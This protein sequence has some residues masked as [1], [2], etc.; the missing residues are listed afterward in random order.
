[1]RK[2]I[3]LFTVITKV[4]VFNSINSTP[5]VAI[6]YDPLSP[7]NKPNPFEELL[8]DAGYNVTS[9]NS[10]DATD[11]SFKSVPKTARLI[12]MRL[13][14]S[15]NQGNVWVFSGE[16]YSKEKTLHRYTRG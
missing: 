11:N 14:S 12:I 3:L 9:Y 6:I 15:I 8:S 4:V 2:H 7:E 10:R 1:M 16:H 13:H 5:Q